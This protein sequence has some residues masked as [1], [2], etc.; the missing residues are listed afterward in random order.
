MH[1]PQLAHGPPTSRTVRNQCLSLKQPGLWDFVIPAVAGLK[2]C[3]K[4]VKET[5]QSN[6]NSNV[7]FRVYAI[8]IRV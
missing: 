4:V 1:P 8:G 6:P 2:Q 3:L 5:K 7:F